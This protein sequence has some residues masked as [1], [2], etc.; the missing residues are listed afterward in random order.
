MLCPIIITVLPMG[1]LEMCTLTSE[2]S[3]HTLE[4]NSTCN[5]CTRKRAILLTQ[6]QSISTMLSAAMHA[7]NVY[8]VS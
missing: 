2:S 8:P 7:P 6:K 3:Q 5:K 4:Q 1:L